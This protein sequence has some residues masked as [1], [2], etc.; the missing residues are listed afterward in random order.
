MYP[1]P[2]FLASPRCCG[3]YDLT[4]HPQAHI[5]SLAKVVG[6]QLTQML[7]LFGLVFMCTW[8]NLEKVN[9]SIQ[10]V[11][12]AL[13]PGTM[14]LHTPQARGPMWW[15][16]ALRS[17]AAIVH[18]PNFSFTPIFC[19]LPSLFL[20]TG[21]IWGFFFFFSI[22]A[23]SSLY[24]KLNNNSK[25]CPIDLVGEIS[26]YVFMWEWRH[27]FRNLFKF[28]IMHKQDKMEMWGRPSSGQCKCEGLHY[29]IGHF[30][31]TAVSLVF[32]SNK[33]TIKKISKYNSQ[34]LTRSAVIKKITFFPWNIMWL[35]MNTLNN[36]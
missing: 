11:T 30:C 8:E 23:Y 15:R 26:H 13:Y 4:I 29:L 27:Q 35:L 17:L 20:R 32:W 21:S 12:L 28:I 25:F 14:G 24:K 7:L 9:C 33:Y 16:Q 31:I 10:D 5:W 3:W 34:S 36:K 22:Y 2:K 1:R 18:D 19:F 6:M